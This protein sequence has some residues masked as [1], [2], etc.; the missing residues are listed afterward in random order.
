MTFGA[1]IVLVEA[2]RAIFGGE[3]QHVSVPAW[4]EGVTQLGFLIYPTYRLELIG[5]I[6]AL[7]FGVYLVL[8]RTSIGLVVRAGIEDARMVGILGINVRRAFL[9]VFAIGVVA[10][11]ARGM[12]YAPIVS[13]TP[14]MGAD[15]P[16]GI[17]RRHRDRRA[18]IVS[19]RGGGRTD[20]GR[21]HQHHQRVQFRLFRGDALRRDG[22]A[23]GGPAARP[24]R[25]GRAGYDPRL[26][27]SLPELALTWCSPSRR[28]SCRISAARSI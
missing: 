12:L 20:R 24:V 28:S 19:G 13:V 7:L 21:D 23:A 9:L 22:A 27:A 14:D 5:I 16:G 3:S 26:A 6:A 10:A 25:L 8:Y 15:I 11:G 2:V 18:G 17:L 4:G 1:G